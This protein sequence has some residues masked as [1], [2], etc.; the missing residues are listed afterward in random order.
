MQEDIKSWRQK[1]Q[2]SLKEKQGLFAS[3]FQAPAND[4]GNNISTVC[5]QVIYYS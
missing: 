5:Y 4:G 2:E 3:G 1:M